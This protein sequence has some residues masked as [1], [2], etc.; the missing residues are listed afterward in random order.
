MSGKYIRVALIHPTV[1]FDDK[2]QPLK[3]H[4]HML[5]IDL[6]KNNKKQ[7]KRLRLTKAKLE[8][9]DSIFKDLFLGMDF[10]NTTEFL[11]QDS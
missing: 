2:L 4:I 1:D 7:L 3:E 6:L 9:E 8:L 10:K 11:I 5:V